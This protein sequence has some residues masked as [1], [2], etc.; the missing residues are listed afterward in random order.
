[1]MEFLPKPYPNWSSAKWEDHY[2]R[3]FAA[4]IKAA[5]GR[6]WGRDNLRLGDVCQLRGDYRLY[7]HKVCKVRGVCTS[8]DGAVLITVS[9]LG[10]NCIA[11][12]WQSS[13][14]DLEGFSDTGMC[15]VWP[16]ELRRI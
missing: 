11:G 12:P 9:F 10:P 3:Q 14:V 8:D 4:R 15:G 1:M 2:I 16:N 5:H 7:P 13:P 6:H